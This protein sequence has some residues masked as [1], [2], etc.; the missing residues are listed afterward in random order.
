MPGLLPLID[1]KLYPAEQYPDG[2]WNYY[3]FYLT[4]FDQTVTDFNADI[5]ASLA[6]IYRSGAPVSAGKMY[7]MYRSAIIARNGGWFGSAHHAPRGRA[8]SRTLAAH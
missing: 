6:A 7:R 4:R 8:R 1:R 3:R 5:P 2:Q